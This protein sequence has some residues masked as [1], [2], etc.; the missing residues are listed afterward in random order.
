VI[1]RETRSIDGE[2]RRYLVLL[3]TGEIR[4]DDL[5][6]RVQEDRLQELGVRPAMSSEEAIDVLDVLAVSKPRLSSNWARRFKNHQA[7]LRSGDVFECAEVV[8]NL[9]L[10]QRDKPLAAAEKAMYHRARTSLVSELAVTWGVSAEAA[11]DRVDGAL[12]P[13]AR[14]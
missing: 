2:L 10:R 8:R 11:A 4:A 13:D 6:V 7:K 14:S 3:I 9:A 1:A 12:A 5:T